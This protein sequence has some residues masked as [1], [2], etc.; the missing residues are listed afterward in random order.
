VLASDAAAQNRLAVLVAQCGHQLVE[1]AASPDAV[2]TDGAADGV[3][4]ASTVAVGAVGGEF[5]GR[6]PP[7]TPAGL[8]S[9]PR[10]APSQRD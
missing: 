8:K 9:T 1:A 3:L 5:A 2:L 6:L 10:C 7:A 4:P